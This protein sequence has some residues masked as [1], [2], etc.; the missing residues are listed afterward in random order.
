MPRFNLLIV[1]VVVLV[2]ACSDQ[3][4]SPTA[5][6]QPSLRSGIADPTPTWTIPAADGVLGFASDGQ[7]AY[8]NGTCGVS[9]ELFSTS[10]ASGSG[11]ATIK[12][13]KT[14]NCARRF[15]L[16]NP[17]GSHETVL[18]FNNLQALESSVLGISIP[19]G[20]SELR[21]LIINPGVIASN[22]STC[23]RIIFGDNG[24]VGAGTDKVEVTRVSADSWNVHSQ[25]GHNLAL[26]EN[27]GTIYPVP[28][29]FVITVP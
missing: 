26:C 4:T 5:A 14:K 2:A 16:L 6:E 12:T 10:A 24:T 28:V 29:S 9:T 19:V 21:R 23:G 17:D 20:N 11:D 13:S 1:P 8:V 22:P 15:T 18:S 3:P 27:L 25:T 7:G